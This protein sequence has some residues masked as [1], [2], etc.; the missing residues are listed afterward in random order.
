MN[1]DELDTKLSKSGYHHP[2]ENNNTLSPYKIYNT[3]N[4]NT[5]AYS[6]I[7]YDTY[8]KFDSIDTLSSCDT[9]PVCHLKYMY[10][11]E[12]SEF[13]DRMCKKGHTWYIKGKNIIVGDPHANEE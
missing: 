3:D 11:C 8:S 10:I 12:C 7:N 1:R 2:T 6:S 5:E 13:K 4:Q 9:C